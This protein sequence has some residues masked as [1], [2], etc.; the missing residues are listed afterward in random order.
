MSGIIRQVLN[1]IHDLPHQSVERN[2]GRFKRRRP[3]IDFFRAL[4][5]SPAQKVVVVVKAI[6]AR[7]RTGKPHELER[8]FE[9]RNHPGFRV[10]DRPQRLN[11]HILKNGPR[12]LNRKERPALPIGIE[13]LEVN[14]LLGL[15]RSENSAG[16]VD[17]GLGRIAV[18]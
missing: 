17:Y 4:I 10:L 11:R 13:L 12:R 15:V 9:I 6:V 5:Q 18:D 1:L 7:N 2:R 3:K 14:L 16:T 8:D